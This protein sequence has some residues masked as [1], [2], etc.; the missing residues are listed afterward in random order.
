MP[1]G[2]LTIGRIDGA[3]H[4]D[5][6]RHRLPRKCTTRARRSDDIDPI[7][8]GYPWNYR[9]GTRRPAS[10]AMALARLSRGRSHAAQSVDVRMS[11]IAARRYS[12]PVVCKES[13]EKEALNMRQSAAK[14][15]TRLQRGG[16]RFHHRNAGSEKGQTRG[17][18]GTQSHRSKG[19]KPHDSGTA[20]GTVVSGQ[21]S[22]AGSTSILL[23]A[24][25]RQR[26][27]AS[28]LSGAARTHIVD[29]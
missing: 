14:H 22:I 28:D 15:A 9:Y 19:R 7:V 24:S 26:R 11:R 17:N 5:S 21:Q 20:W 12:R 16:L 25:P 10:S 18:A 23:C 6:R 4:R 1:Q 13:C 29:S 2:G 3:A 27:C 8:G